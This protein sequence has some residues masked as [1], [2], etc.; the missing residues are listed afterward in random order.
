MFTTSTKT[1]IIKISNSPPFWD[2]S[3]PAKL[4]YLLR[5]CGALQLSKV[6]RWV[7]GTQ[8]DGLE[9]VHAR[10][11]KEE[12]RIRERSDGGRRY[13]VPFQSVYVAGWRGMRKKN[14]GR[15]LPKV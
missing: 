10:I 15:L 12:S 3:S 5:V 4:Q 9:L 13:Y 14:R 7:N 6:R 2:F 1:L 11:C 8:E